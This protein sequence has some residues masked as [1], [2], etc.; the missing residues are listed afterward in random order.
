VPFIA[1]T[2]VATSV[3]TTKDMMVVSVGLAAYA[4]SGHVFRWVRGLVSFAEQ[5]R[6]R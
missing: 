3:S 5:T 1:L 6:M 2:L 4:Y